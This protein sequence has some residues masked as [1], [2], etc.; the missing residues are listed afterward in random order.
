MRE[1]ITNYS[2]VE[3]GNQ[4]NVFILRH[5]TDPNLN[6]NI[7][8]CAGE[9]GDKPRWE[10]LPAIMGMAVEH[11]RIHEQV[12]NPL[13]C[14]RIAFQQLVTEKVGLRPRSEIIDKFDQT[15]SEFR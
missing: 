7:R 5:H 1:P 9:D 8:C 15:R 6:W 4:Q 14:M 12:N 10:G 11:M 2:N 13:Y 3:Q